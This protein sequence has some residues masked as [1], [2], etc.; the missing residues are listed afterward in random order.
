MI[1]NRRHLI[2]SGL[3]GA[4]ATLAP[5]MAFAAAETDRRYKEPELND[6]RHNVSEIAVFHIKCCKP[7]PKA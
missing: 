7:E 2:L 4:T 6:K 1:V 3:A 5:R